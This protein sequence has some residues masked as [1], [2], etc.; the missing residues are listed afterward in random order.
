MALLAG[1]SMWPQGAASLVVGAMARSGT[2]ILRRLLTQNSFF[3]VACLA[4]D[5]V[6]SRRFLVVKPSRGAEI[7]TF[8]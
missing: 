8:V 6:E 3:V 4:S 2:R 1:S 7:L 5:D